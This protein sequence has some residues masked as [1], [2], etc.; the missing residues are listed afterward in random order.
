[1]AWLERSGSIARSTV[2]GVAL[3][4]SCDFVIVYN[5]LKNNFMGRLELD[6]RY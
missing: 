6:W 3:S 4:F 5:K 2:L 1:M